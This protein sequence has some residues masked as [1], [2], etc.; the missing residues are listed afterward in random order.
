MRTPK[1]HR[2]VGPSWVVGGVMQARSQPLINEMEAFTTASEN[3]EGVE[4]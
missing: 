2:P 1:A 3:L 4:E